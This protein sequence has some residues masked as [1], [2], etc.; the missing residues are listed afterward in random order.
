VLN[1]ALQESVYVHQREDEAHR[2]AAAAAAAEL[3]KQA[4]E[5][6]VAEA[7]ATIGCVLPA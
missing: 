1:R 2:I 3:A 6:K 7:K 5:A 4:A